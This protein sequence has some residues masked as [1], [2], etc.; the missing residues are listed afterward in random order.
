[1]PQQINALKISF[2]KLISFYFYY[3]LRLHFSCLHFLSDL[4]AHL[5]TTISECVRNPD[6]HENDL[7]VDLPHPALLFFFFLFLSNH[8]QVLLL[9]ILLVLQACVCPCKYVFVHSPS[10]TDLHLRAHDLLE[11]TRSSLTDAYGMTRSK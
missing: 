11:R 9:V 3:S 10:L 5:F 1:M 4:K 6:L 2:K 8:V 7:H